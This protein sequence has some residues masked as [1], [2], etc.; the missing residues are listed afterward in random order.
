MLNQTFSEAQTETKFD[1]FGS[2]ISNIEL[3]V[4]ACSILLL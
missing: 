3:Y 2:L 1:G 4:F